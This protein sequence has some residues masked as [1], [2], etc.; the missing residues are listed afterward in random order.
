MFSKKNEFQAGASAGVG[1]HVRTAYSVTNHLGITASYLNA[2]NRGLNKALDGTQWRIHNVGEVGIGYYTNNQRNRYM[3]L[4]A[5]AGWGKGV[6]HNTMGY[7]SWFSLW[8]GE[9]S[10]N[11]DRY[12]AKGKYYKIYLQP[13]IGWRKKIFSWNASLRFTYLNFTDATAIL[14][15][16]PIKFGENP[17]VMVSSGGEFRVAIIKEKLYGS[18]QAGLM[19]YTTVE[20]DFFYYEFVSLSAGIMVKL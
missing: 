10:Y 6:A 12:D 11:R 18:A 7:S 4:F 1:L 17:R 15:D 9:D 5:G 8:P 3:D 16:E 2:N 13:A 20:E 14:N 19:L